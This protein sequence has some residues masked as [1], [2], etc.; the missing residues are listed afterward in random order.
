MMEEMWWCPIHTARRWEY[1]DRS[2]DTLQGYCIRY[3]T[4]L[5]IL[6]KTE[7]ECDKDVKRTKRTGAPR[8]SVCHNLDKRFQVSIRAILLLNKEFQLSELV[9]K[10][11][12]EYRQC[13]YADTEGINKDEVGRGRNSI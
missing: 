13:V 3:R 7:K 8:E 5:G 4:C 11:E 6:E 9:K 12:D 2:L 10:I 1:H